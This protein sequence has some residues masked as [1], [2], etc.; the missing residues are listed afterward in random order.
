MFNSDILTVGSFMLF[1]D[2][3]SFG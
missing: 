1:L 3:K 2:I